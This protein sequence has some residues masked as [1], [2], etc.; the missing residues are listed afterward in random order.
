MA[1]FSV[2][3]NKAASGTQI[4]YLLDVQSGLLDQ[5]E[6]RVVV[7]LYRLDAFKG[8][9]FTKLTPVFEIEGVRVIMMTSELAGVQK[10]QLGSEAHSLVRH[11]DEIVAALDMLIFGI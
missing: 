7:P 4:P 11:H 1:Q 2:Y 5:L 10:K 3:R 9:V 8:K 6:T